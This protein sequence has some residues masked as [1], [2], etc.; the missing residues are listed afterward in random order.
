[1]FNYAVQCYGL[2]SREAI[3]VFNLYKSYTDE[4][5][6]DCANVHTMTGAPVHLTASNAN[7]SVSEHEAVLCIMKLVCGEHRSAI[8][9]EAG[10]LFRQRPCDFFIKVGRAILAKQ[11]DLKPEDAHSVKSI[12][13]FLT[14]LEAKKGLVAAM[15]YATQVTWNGGSATAEFT[16]DGFPKIKDKGYGLQLR[17]PGSVSGKHPD[18]S[19]H[20]LNQFF[21]L[22][23]LI[24]RQDAKM[25]MS[26]LDSLLSNRPEG[27][28]SKLKNVTIKQC[29]QIT[30]ANVEQLRTKY[31]DVTFTYI[32]AKPQ[33]A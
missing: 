11:E 23:T 30:D 14:L 9:E 31:G 32:A 17:T 6:S 4:S 21:G 22:E 27:A 16:G 19:F 10:E 3:Q 33:G 5:L 2:N 28:T 26:Q 15:Q 13:T 12:G 20:Q 1:V 25:T 18:I 24:V 7:V 8:I 29:A